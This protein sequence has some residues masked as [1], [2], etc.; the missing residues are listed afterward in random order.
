MQTAIQVFWFRLRPLVPA[1]YLVLT[2]SFRMTSRL[3]NGLAVDRRKGEGLARDLAPGRARTKIGQGDERID[4]RWSVAF[5]KSLGRVR[6][7]KNERSVND[8]ADSA[9][10]AD[11]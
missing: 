4:E 1:G 10:R 7:S 6:G 11:W 3:G 2:V 8:Y 5:S 9:G